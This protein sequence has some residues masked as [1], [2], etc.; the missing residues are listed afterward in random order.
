[1]DLQKTITCHWLQDSCGPK[2][3]TMHKV[4][5]LCTEMSFTLTRCWI[6]CNKNSSKILTSATKFPQHS[7]FFLHNVSTW[8]LYRAISN[9]GVG[10]D[11]NP[12]QLNKDPIYFLGRNSC[13]ARSAAAAGSGWVYPM[14]SGCGFLPGH[15]AQ[16]NHALQQNFSQNIDGHGVPQRCANS[17]FVKGLEQRIQHLLRPSLQSPCLSYSQTSVQLGHKETSLFGL[18]GGF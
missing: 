13:H 4:I 11:H 16:R 1:M 6:S 15:V 18:W 12:G 14:I 7:I 2:Q 5:N 9:A 3:I 17:G 8:S 10:S